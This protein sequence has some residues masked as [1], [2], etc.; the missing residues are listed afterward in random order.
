MHVDR[1]LAVFFVKRVSVAGRLKLGLDLL[2]GC[3]RD[4]EQ[5]VGVGHGVTGPVF[6][7]ADSATSLSNLAIF[8]A[9]LG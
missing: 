6:G 5:R 8:L 3:G 4:L 1:H 9:S 2:V 7:S